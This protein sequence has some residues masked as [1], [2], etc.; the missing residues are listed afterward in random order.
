MGVEQ[1]RAAVGVMANSVAA[2]PQSPIDPHWKKWLKASDPVVYKGC[3]VFLVVVAQL[4]WSGLEQRKEKIKEDSER[5]CQS[6][7]RGKNQVGTRPYE[8]HGTDAVWTRWFDS[9]QIGLIIMLS[10]LTQLTLS[11]KRQWNFK[12]HFVHSN[13]TTV[14]EWIKSLSVCV[15]LVLLSVRMFLSLLKRCLHCSASLVYR[16]CSKKTVAEGVVSL[17]SLL[18]S[19]SVRTGLRVVTMIVFVNQMLLMRA[20]DVERNPGP[21]KCDIPYMNSTMSCLFLTDVL[22]LDDLGM[23]VN[24]LHEERDVWFSLGV[25]LK[26]PVS[27]LRAIRTQHSNPAD[28]LIEMLTSWLTTITASPP[29]WQSVVDVLNCASIRRHHTAEKIMKKY[30][31]QD[32]G[33]GIVILYM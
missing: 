22:T 25:Q 30:C 8:I 18:F 16:K 29:T 19:T 13:L 17:M 33:T 10:P 15:Y 24:E 9:R 3:V 21:G 12:S 27:E 4:V 11:I 20:G 14:K 6:T 28:C 5:L 26:V 7:S 31:T 32:V 2:K 1:W 23:L